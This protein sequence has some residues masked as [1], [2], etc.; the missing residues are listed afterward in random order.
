MPANPSPDYLSIV[1]AYARGRWGSA[2]EKARCGAGDGRCAN[3]WGKG[4][5]E[6]F[7]CTGRHDKFKRLQDVAIGQHSSDANEPL[8]QSFLTFS[9]LERTRHRGEQE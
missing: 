6:F 1:R 3:S 2:K 4:V 7:D 5:F 8:L 9:H